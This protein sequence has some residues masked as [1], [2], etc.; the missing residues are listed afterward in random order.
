VQTSNEMRARLVALS[1]RSQAIV[2]KADR[3]HRDITE[4]EAQEIDDVFGEF[5]RTE[6]ALKRGSRYYAAL[7][8]RLALAG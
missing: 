4:A 8:L 1:E 7:R 2:G 6:A 5:E 3:E